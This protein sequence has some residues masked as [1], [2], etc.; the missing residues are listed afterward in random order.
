MNRKDLNL[1]KDVCMVVPAV[2]LTA[3]AVLGI[4]V[5]MGLSSWVCRRGRCCETS[6]LDDLTRVRA[7]DRRNHARRLKASIPAPVSTPTP[8]GSD[9]TSPKS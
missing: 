2:A 3:A 4:A 6:P 1:V 7:T 8:D 5:V 9:P